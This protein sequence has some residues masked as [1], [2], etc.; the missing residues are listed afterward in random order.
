[1][2][3]CI[4]PCR[5]KG[6]Q[7]LQRLALSQLYPTH[8][9]Q[10]KCLLFPWQA[11]PWHVPQLYF[12]PGT[13]VRWTHQLGKHRESGLLCYAAVT[14]SPAWLRHPI[15]SDIMELAPARTSL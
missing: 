6:R 15:N 10:R 9:H 11:V 12:P 14:L 1:M 4:I 13:G 2:V 7:L 3:V 5:R 8:L